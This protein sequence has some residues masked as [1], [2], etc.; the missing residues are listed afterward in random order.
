MKLF[1]RLIFSFILLLWCTLIFIDWIIPFNENVIVVV[2][3]IKKTFS[4]VC[5]QQEYKLISQ[6]VFH[7]MVCSR[8]AGIYT[9]AF[10]ASLALLFFTIKKKFG[11]RLFYFAVIP[12]L[13]DIFCYTLNIYEYSKPV[14][15][16]TGLLLGSTGFLYF[17]SAVNQ[18]IIEKRVK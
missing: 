13:A 8:C 2:P 15:F 10:I 3:I 6:N 14:A 11:N 18:F 16:A 12:M 7:S 17:Y 9:G 5:H 1:I 4:L